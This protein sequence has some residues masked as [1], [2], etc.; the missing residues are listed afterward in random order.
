[1]IS[2]AD[3]NNTI[4]LNLLNIPI[5]DSLEID[6]PEEEPESGLLLEVPE[7]YDNDPYKG[8]IYHSGEEEVESEVT[9]GSFVQRTF[10]SSS[11]DESGAI[12]GA[13]MRSGWDTRDLDNNTAMKASDWAKSKAD[14]LS[15]LKKTKFGD[16]GINE[17]LTDKPIYGTMSEDTRASLEAG[18][19]QVSLALKADPDWLDTYYNKLARNHKLSV[20]SWEDYDKHIEDPDNNPMPELHRLGR[21][22]I[23]A[24]DGNIANVN[25]GEYGNALSRKFGQ[26]GS[27]NLG[28]KLF[29]WSN[30]TSPIIRGS[31]R[32]KLDRQVKMDQAEVSAFVPYMNY[33][34]GHD[35][36][37]GVGDPSY[38]E[39]AGE[40]SGILATFLAPGSGLG[41]PAVGVP[42][43]SGARML[44]PG[45]LATEMGRKGIQSLM[46]NLGVRQLGRTLPKTGKSL[47]LTTTERISARAT[48]AFA[49]GATWSLMMQ[50]DGISGTEE[51]DENYWLNAI[52][53]ETAQALVDGTT[54]AVFGEALHH[55]SKATNPI[56]NRIFYGVTNKIR[57]PEQF[58]AYLNSAKG[59]ID[60]PFR[61]L[62]KGQ[63]K[64]ALEDDAFFGM[65]AHIAKKNGVKVRYK[66]DKEGAVAFDVLSPRLWTNAFPAIRAQMGEIGVRFAGKIKETK[67][68]KK[69]PKDTEF[70]VKSDTELLANKTGE[71][72]EKVTTPEPIN[73]TPVK[74]KDQLDPGLNFVSGVERSPADGASAIV[75]GGSV[76]MRINEDLGKKAKEQII[77]LTKGGRKVFIEHGLYKPGQMVEAEGDSF[78]EL[79]ERLEDLVQLGA[80]PSNLMVVLPDILDSG[81]GTKALAKDAFYQFNK[82]PKLKDV[83]FIYPLQRLGPGGKFSMEALP[84]L[85]DP[86]WDGAKLIIG[87]P[88]NFSRVRPNEL[89]SMFLNHLGDDFK[90]FH[91]LGV[92]PASERGK[93]LIRIIREEVPDSVISADTALGRTS[94]NAV[95]KE[96][97]EGAARDLGLVYNESEDENWT[98]W[99]DEL[100]SSNPQEMEWSNAEME[101]LSKLV[102][103]SESDY[104]DVFDG[105]T[106]GRTLYE[107]EEDLGIEL[108]EDTHGGFNK[109]T[110]SKILELLSPKTTRGKWIEDQTKKAT[111][112]FDP[113][114]PETDSDTPIEVTDPGTDSDT[115][116][117]GVGNGHS[118]RLSAYSD[119]DYEVNENGVVMNP[120][121]EVIFSKGALKI[122]VQYAL[123]KEG[124]DFRV[125]YESGGEGRHGP[126]R[127]DEKSLYKY[128]DLRDSISAPE[129]IRKQ[130]IR[131]GLELV[132]R[133]LNDSSS[134]KKL[135]TLAGQFIKE[136]GGED[137]QFDPPKPILVAGLK[138]TYKVG[139]DKLVTDPDQ[140]P[141]FKDK[142]IEIT[143]TFAEFQDGVSYAWEVTGK[144]YGFRKWGFPLKYDPDSL[145]AMGKDRKKPGEPGYDWARDN[146]TGPGRDIRGGDDAMLWAK[147]LE[148]AK[149]KVI[150]SA[151]SYLVGSG[152]PDKAKLVVAKTMGEVG[153]EWLKS[154][155]P[156]LLE[157]SD[158]PDKAPL[159][160]IE[161]AIQ[162][163][164]E[165]WTEEFTTGIN[166]DRDNWDPKVSEHASA[167]LHK[168]TE[169]ITQAS[170]WTVEALIDR[171]HAVNEKGA[172]VMPASEVKAL[173]KE[174]A[175]GVRAPR[176]PKTRE[177]LL[178]LFV[179]NKLRAKET[180][181]AFYKVLLELRKNTVS[182]Q[183]FPEG[184]DR[185]VEPK[186]AYVDFLKEV[187]GIIKDNK[188]PKELEDLMGVYK[189]V[190]VIPG[191]PKLLDDALKVYN[192]KVKQKEDIEEV[193]IEVVTIE[194]IIEN[195]YTAPERP[196]VKTSKK[197]DALRVKQQKEYLTEKIKLALLNVPADPYIS[198]GKKG[199]EIKARL[200]ND[201]GHIMDGSSE[202]QRDWLKG[203]MDSGQLPYVLLE[204]PYDGQIR[205]LN[206]KYALTRFSK[207]IKSLGT[208]KSPV[209]KGKPS[210]GSKRNLSLP[211]AKR[212]RS[213]LLSSFLYKGDTEKLSKF[214]KVIQLPAGP[215][216]P[217]VDF[218]TDTISLLVLPGDP[219]GKY[220]PS[221]DL[222]LD[223]FIKTFGNTRKLNK[224]NFAKLGPKP[225]SKNKHYRVNP[226]VLMQWASNATVSDMSK[227]TAMERIS[228]HSGVDGQL[229]IRSA[230]VNV[231]WNSLNHD[232]TANDLV[233]ISTDR[234][235]KIAKVSEALDADYVQVSFGSPADPPIFEFFDSKDNLLG[236]AGVAPIESKDSE[237]SGYREEYNG[238]S[239]FRTKREQCVKYLEDYNAK[240]VVRSKFG[241]SQVEGVINSLVTGIEHDDMVGSIS[242]QRQLFRAFAF[243]HSDLNGSVKGLLDVWDEYRHEMERAYINL[244]EDQLSALVNGQIAISDIIE[245]A[246]ADAVGSPENSNLVMGGFLKS[247]RDNVSATRLVG[248]NLPDIKTESG[249][250]AFMHMAEAL[251]SPH[252]EY[253]HLIGVKNGKI[254]KTSTVTANL[255]FATWLAP[256]KSGGSDREN[257]DK[258]VERFG[259]GMDYTFN[260]HNHPSGDPTPS[261]AD[262]GM[263]SVG[264]A[265]S[266][267]SI[268]INHGKYSYIPS[269]LAKVDHWAPP[270]LSGRV[271]EI[272]NQQDLNL[273]PIVDA[274]AL[275]SKFPIR[276]VSLIPKIEEMLKDVNGVGPDGRGSGYM[277]FHLS[278]AHR[279]RAVTRHHVD[280][281][282]S[283]EKFYQDIKDESVRFGS[284]EVAVYS[285]KPNSVG[286][287]NLK[288]AFDPLVSELADQDKL[289]LFM[290]G[291]GDGAKGSGND[292]REKPK[293]AE[294][295]MVYED[296]EK[297]DSW[298]YWEDPLERLGGATSE[299]VDSPIEYIT[300]D[301]TVVR[302]QLNLAPIPPIE[303]PEI[304]EL[305]QELTGALPKVKSL[306]PTKMGYFQPDGAEVVINKDIFGTRGDRAVKTLA[307]EFGHVDDF[308]G[309]VNTL[310]RGNLL[311]RLMG[312]VEFKGAGIPLFMGGAGEVVLIT[313]N[314]RAKIKYDVRKQI[315]SEILAEFE[316]KAIEAEY[317]P[318]L[319]KNASD[320][321]LIEAYAR[322]LAQEKQPVKLLQTPLYLKTLEQLEIR[323]K[324]ES[325]K[326]YVTRLAEL[327]ATAGVAGNKQVRAELLALMDW[328][329]PIPQD[330][331]LSYQKYRAKGEELY[332][333]ALSLMFMAPNELQ[334]RAP[335]FWQT[336]FAYLPQKPQLEKSLKAMWELIR[337]QK[338][339][340]VSGSI[341]MRRIERRRQQ[342]VSLEHQFIQE[343]IDQRLP[344]T[345]VKEFT[346]LMQVQ[347]HDYAFGIVD[348][349]REMKSKHPKGTSGAG[350]L[351]RWDKDPEA[352]WGKHPYS[353]NGAALWL[354]RMHRKIISQLPETGL[355]IEWLGEY[356]FLTRIISEKN[357]RGTGRSQIANEGGTT[358][359]TAQKDL[360]NLG[361]YLGGDNLSRLRFSAQHLRSAFFEIYEEA[362]SLGL[363]SP[364]QFKLIRANKENYATF[365]N[366]DH[367]F[368]KRYIPSGIRNQVGSFK[369]IVNPVTALLL[370][371]V[372]ALKVNEWQRAKL[373]TIEFMENYFPGEIE[374]LEH[375]FVYNRNTEVREK[376][377]DKAIERD[378]AYDRYKGEA[379]MSV[380][381]G[382][383]LFKY[384]VPWDIAIAEI[385]TDPA[386]NNGIW[387]IQN[388]I[389]R[390][391]FYQLYITYN[392]Y[393][394]LISSPMKDFN[395]SVVNMPGKISRYRMLKEWKQS[396]AESRKRVEGKV[397][398]LIAEMMSVGAI[399]TPF[400]NF[401]EKLYDDPDSIFELLL[402][403]QKLWPKKQDS[404]LSKKTLKFL[405]KLFTPFDKILKIGQ[406]F[407]TVAKIAPYKILTRDLGVSP[408][409]AGE[410]VRNH[411]GVPPYIKKGTKS[412]IL[413][414]IFP[415]INV[416]MKG[417]LADARL[418]LGRRSGLKTLK[419]RK[420]FLGV[421]PLS[422]G[423]SGGGVIPPPFGSTPSSDDPSHGGRPKGKREDS[424]NVDVAAGWWTRYFRGP[425]MW[426]MLRDL[427]RMGLLG[428]GL[429]RIWEYIPEYDSNNYNCI[430][431]GYVS[432]D[433][434]GADSFLPPLEDEVPNNAEAIYFK[435]P[436]D[437]T[438]KLLGGVQ[439]RLIQE[440]M[441][442]ILGDTSL[443]KLNSGSELFNFIR[444][445]VPGLS[446]VID[447]PW[448]WLQFGSGYNPV[449]SFRGNNILTRAEQ[450]SRSWPAYEKMIQYTL[451]DAGLSSFVRYDRDTDTS[452]EYFLKN[453]PGV[454]GTVGRL[455][456]TSSH[457][458]VEK[459]FR[460]QNDQTQRYAEIRVSH[461]S[462]TQELHR[463]W[464]R[465]YQLNETNRELVDRAQKYDDLDYWYKNMYQPY[466]D[467]LKTLSDDLT[468]DSLSMSERK[469]IKK[470]MKDIQGFIELLA[471]ENLEELR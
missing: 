208:A 320:K 157:V 62:S 26:Y 74:P 250:T 95:K 299:L 89:R 387:Y 35:R 342:W 263:A 237:I 337:T 96:N 213:A 445:Q 160:Y 432:V 144:G 75:G 360:L 301:G 151:I 394:Q 344:Y 262:L 203:L 181:L 416:A 280:R 4:D 470:E 221:D 193:E 459:G 339:P 369:K 159:V 108:A 82:S 182:S 154:N 408:V 99:V 174:V 214:K 233:V 440:A 3:S 115:P 195:P 204:V 421:G 156:D 469:K 382:G 430:P 309:Q 411:M 198:L 188:L 270:F 462:A 310:S 192:Y 242:Q 441:A 176:Q 268:V 465:L 120:E 322:F 372:C 375:K 380:M 8:R 28:K 42:S 76:G 334:K 71:A 21:G 267:G 2:S 238:Q 48:D 404:R 307:H 85:D 201:K 138:R 390:K 175:R 93:N 362:Y 216:I 406:T 418:A 453:I 11:L 395:R 38:W 94:V 34:A 438:H 427:G 190:E 434:S 162:L 73:P 13:V 276:A 87:I 271:H 289:Y 105:L 367:L 304:V 393:F 61:S 330:A 329:K 368:D 348:R 336:F 91:L 6:P 414:S 419:D 27:F 363:Y 141:I 398:P 352:I 18:F 113:P 19:R 452:L 277:V 202:G 199:A 447:L 31:D 196:N 123:F 125:D 217:F 383:Q 439:S 290:T 167:Q 346:R 318:N 109:F 266:A 424:D 168:L 308:Y 137:D 443:S 464:S 57:T 223:N 133:I 296:G 364:E 5:D 206:T 321:S 172:D 466:Y 274:P 458:L 314:D 7:D 187:E 273:T 461:G 178:K 134:T 142:N 83:R 143:L 72:I 471:S 423:G 315:M 261:Q 235:V 10:D 281:E 265:K 401:A 272:A 127:S 428:E 294:A 448:T 140:R 468:Q 278:P 106:A 377:Y 118:I 36:M 100:W 455:V 385:G 229:A 165:T 53:Q 391:F 316:D 409:E 135:K 417:Y 186:S 226:S 37:P 312:A 361:K 150:R 400:D 49:S 275:G 286:E 311:G 338:K 102:S 291:F 50:N 69:A 349:V 101:E 405:N 212:G 170:G 32:S 456:K 86:D 269:K 328:W 351:Y 171:L 139:V 16:Y 114:E 264:G 343:D 457:G 373:R 359:K 173:V 234:F 295:R 403:R 256:Y 425:G 80:E 189:Q 298:D 116:I 302:T 327:T 232:K 371:G 433:K 341:S 426:A 249:R 43:Q 103:F 166:T 152:D 402:Q 345:S 376:K 253:G 381:R 64:V 252:F 131:V 194:E 355:S 365:A 366:V 246:Q 347:H 215:D 227:D 148:S 454:N 117:D 161:Q 358:A 247:I 92:D 132:K 467:D 169:H 25:L 122:S 55:V 183:N 12:V 24:N 224:S 153:A 20:D 220:T 399:G 288:K 300:A 258:F 259:E 205:V 90:E 200:E 158:E 111:A 41:K 44:M 350:D 444:Q 110:M 407:E 285:P 335:I 240:Y 107:I 52:K 149:K 306:K 17:I 254:V 415:F 287:V 121:S 389:F 319:R 124:F 68:P 244:G 84:D 422:G 317:E 9:A 397:T 180:K 451:D 211:K 163:L 370:K 59:R 46:A 70:S 260:V 282:F 356:L 155:F 207:Q 98:D 39:T 112:I 78:V 33:M 136:F 413:Q 1:M 230:G 251:R 384:V 67:Q 412:Y 436:V 228:L 303:S 58:E 77:D 126:V 284:F 357:E 257:H 66:S 243:G 255:S 463:D 297:E 442:H 325:R 54:F 435:L 450:D 45:A 209:I 225:L 354:E 179:P 177:Q 292:F 184:H 210:L 23:E 386:S 63:Q 446:P 333:D 81:I 431:L 164:F 305:I 248:Q 219:K 437:E 324:V 410:Y 283:A 323:V 331:D 429:R 145:W 147:D 218:A 378:L 129:Y 104:Q 22:L 460:L 197:V 56:T 396:W 236:Y 420:R 51:L 119:R 245:Q 241:P 388:L 222:N 231:Q 279:I 88:G 60:K 326:R 30:D 65:L 146:A 79:K 191:W 185:N 15:E 449:D 239:Y 392:P 340:G 379:V 293:F 374:E 40:F 353:N 130:G 29:E 97:M 128:E 332:A 313:S 47:P 14:E